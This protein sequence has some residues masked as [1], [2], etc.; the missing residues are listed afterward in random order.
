MRVIV[1]SKDGETALAERPEMLAANPLSRFVR[2]GLTLFILVLLV[3]LNA[4]AADLIVR[5]E[6]V[7]TMSG[8]PITD[9]VVVIRNG[10]ITAVGASSAI[11]IPPGVRT[12]NAKVVTPGLVDAHSVIGLAGYLNQTSDQGQLEKSAPIQPDLRAIDGYDTEEPLIA[13]V[14]GFGVTTL[15]TGHGPGA[16]I[17]GQTM[18][19][20][21][22]GRTVDDAVLRPVAMVAATLGESALAE[23]GKSP[24]TR[25]KEISMLRTELIKAQQYQKKLSTAAEDKKP[26]RDLNLDVLASV[27]NRE[28]PLLI[29]VN[30]A[31]DIMSA[32]RLAK[33]FNLKIV[34][35]G[36]A[37]AYLVADAIKLAAVQ[38]ILHPTMA[39][40]GGERE[41]LSFETASVLRAK[42]IPF[43]LQSGYE[44][45][46]PKTRVVLFEAG[47]AAAH[48][49][50]FEQALATITIDAAR[51]IGVGD[52][53]GSLEVGKDG[54]LALFDG[55][56]FEF[57]SHTTAVVI[58]GEVVSDKPK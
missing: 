47:V 25:A 14:R 13:W 37:E 41:N 17:S 53:V 6:T 46:V 33:E 7:H 49:L 45:Y 36:V 19:V 5:G 54:D 38:V 31:Q 12:I 44:G 27:L 10:K 9:G 15:H 35:D 22:R 2:A 48:G 24:G 39:R 3:P 50:T 52:R 32:L 16:L 42:G 57:T 21:T 40:A 23:S 8:A 26:G 56:P 1:K 11:V 30:R 43:A 58:D 20:K 34:L 55:D 28:L 4:S 51:I 29:T 18:V